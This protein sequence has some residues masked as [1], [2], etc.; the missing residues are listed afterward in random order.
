MARL[1]GED[2]SAVKHGTEIPPVPPQKYRTI[3]ELTAK[4]IDRFVYWMCGLGCRRV[5]HD[6]RDWGCYRCGKR[7]EVA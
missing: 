1:L 2:R 6:W 4:L 7:E 3:V 5:G